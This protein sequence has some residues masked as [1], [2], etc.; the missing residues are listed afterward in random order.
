MSL[1]KYKD[2]IIFAVGSFYVY[3]DVIKTIKSYT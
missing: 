1:E 2:Y 3:G